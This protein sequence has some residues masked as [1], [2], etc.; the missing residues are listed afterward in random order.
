MHKQR[1]IL[2]DILRTLGIYAVVA[3][4][5]SPFYRVIPGYSALVF[6]VWICFAISGFLIGYLHSGDY[7]TYSLQDSIA[8]VKQKLRR[9]YPLHIAM[10]LFSLILILAGKWDNNNAS[11]TPLMIAVSAMLNILLLQSY[12]PDQKIYF[13]FNGPSWFLS[14]SM[15]L[16]FLTP[17]FLSKVSKR[18]TGEQITFSA[19]VVFAAGMCAAIG[20]AC[21]LDPGL[22]FWIWYVSPFGRVFEFFVAILAGMLFAHSAS[23]KDIISKRVIWMTVLCGILMAGYLL[24]STKIMVLFKCM[25]VAAILLT[26][27]AAKLSHTVDKRNHNRMKALLCGSSFELFIVHRQV[28]RVFVMIW[29]SGT[30]NRFA[31]FLLCSILCILIGIA[32]KYLADLITLKL[33]SIDPV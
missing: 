10:F 24:C 11:D 25:T 30:I 22:D 18:K 26:F 31:G 21:F 5:I 28:I 4:H 6:G 19:L 13:A 12:S 3:Y 29:P 33:K 14:T 16:Y 20:A 2:L 1:F 27:F 7:E 15:T 23:L 9:F 8:F 32:V 17:W